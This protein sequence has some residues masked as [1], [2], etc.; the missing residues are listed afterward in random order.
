MGSHGGATAEGQTELLEGYG[1]TLENTGA[2]I[3]A[4]MEVENVVPFREEA[5]EFA[6]HPIY[7]DR[8]AF[9]ADA[10]LLINRIK[11]H[12]DFTAEME[13]GIGKMSVIGLG[14]QKGAASIHRH[15]AHGLRNLLPCCLFHGGA[16]ADSRRDRA[17][18]K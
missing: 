6:G 8:Y 16:S 17:A 11:A 7:C 1:V 13:S 14:K 4:T 15:G 18:G 2:E 3:R 12:T 9:A 5:G 10:I